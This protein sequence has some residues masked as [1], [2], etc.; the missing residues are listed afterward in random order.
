M[1]ATEDIRY[2][3]YL[4]QYAQ[5]GY[6]SALLSSYGVSSPPLEQAVVL[7]LGCAYGTN[8][9]VMA[10]AH[11]E[12]R[13]IG[14]DID[15]EAIEEAQ[16]VAQEAKLTNVEFVASSNML[17]SLKHHTFDY[18]LAHG[19]F[20]WVSDEVK[21]EILQLCQTTLSRDGV[22]YI[23]YNCNPGW[24]NAS[25]IRELFINDIK[26]VKGAERIDRFRDKLS[27]FKGALQNVSDNKKA[28]AYLQRE[29]ELLEERN[30]GFLAGEMFSEHNDPFYISEFCQWLDE[31]ELEYLGDANPA[32]HIQVDPPKE[33]QIL[34]GECSGNVIKQL[35]TI[36]FLEHRKFRSSLVRKKRSPSAIKKESPEKNSTYKLH[37]PLKRMVKHGDCIEITLMDEKVIRA[38]HFSAPFFSQFESSHIASTGDT[39]QTLTRAQKPDFEHLLLTLLSSH[40]I[41]PSSDSERWSP[42]CE[43]RPQ[44]SLLNR[45]FHKKYGFIYNANKR[46]VSPPNLRSLQ[47]MDGRHTTEEIAQATKTSKE[48]VHETILLLNQHQIY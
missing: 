1:R 45:V 16:S 40:F 24:L 28:K 34:I 47:Y 43:K 8:L 12:A 9:L 17:E 44:I 32:L 29:V 11:P 6:L 21:E 30:D 4:H 25:S 42:I 18:I 35:Q 19:L 26:N 46:S 7:E 41:I 27:S 3:A 10:E 36:D 22:G 20:S 5:I 38:P 31:Y 33:V 15:L 23:N 2:P 14:F 37:S 48:N 39:F 13:F